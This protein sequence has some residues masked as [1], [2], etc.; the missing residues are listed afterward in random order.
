MHKKLGPYYSPT[1]P[2]VR[3]YRAMSE[4]PIISME[5]LLMCQRMASIDY[6][7]IKIKHKGKASDYFCHNKD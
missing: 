7:G 3:V 2:E 4:E 1:C 5:K 6:V